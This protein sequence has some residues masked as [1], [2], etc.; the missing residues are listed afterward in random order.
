[1]KN[2]EQVPQKCDTQEEDF[3]IRY[4]QIAEEDSVFF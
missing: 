3:S 2:S 1:M 4:K